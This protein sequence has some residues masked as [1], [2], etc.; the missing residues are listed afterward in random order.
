RRAPGP[1]RQRGDDRAG[2][3]RVPGHP[4]PRGLDLRAALP[5]SSFRRRALPRVFHAFRGP[6]TCAGRARAGGAPATLP[7]CHDAAPT[8]YARAAPRPPA[9]VGRAALDVQP[10]GHRAPVAARVRVGGSRGLSPRSE[11]AWP[12]PRGSRTPPPPRRPA[13][14]PVA[15]QTGGP[16]TVPLRHATARWVSSAERWGP[17][18]RAEDTRG[19]RILVTLEA[20]G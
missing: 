14:A 20:R 19:E 13:A 7:E 18:P 10:G 6:A 12:R 5:G 16:D 4:R 1:R 17:L 15:P 11:G 3:A 9:V 8:Q 2:A